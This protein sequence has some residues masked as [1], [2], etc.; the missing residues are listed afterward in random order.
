MATCLRT[1]ACLLFV[2]CAAAVWQDR[3]GE[4]AAIAVEISGASAA[5]SASSSAPIGGASGSK[6]VIE[7]KEDA[8]A[9]RPKAG[10]I[11]GRISNEK[12]GHQA[13]REL[14][15]VSR[16][17]G[18]RY[19]P[20]SFDKEKGA[21]EFK[22]MPGDANY[23]VCVTTED[24]RRI[25]GIDLDFVD[26]GLLRLAEARRDELKMPPD[27]QHAFTSDDAAAL[28]K[29]VADLQDFMEIRRP[30]Y[31][32]GHGRRATM[33]VEL[34]RTREFYSSGDALLWRVELWYFQE[35][36]GAWERV[37]NQEVV[38][39][40]KRITPKEW[41]GIDLEFYPQFS[42]HVG[43]MG[44]AKPMELVIPQAPEA[45]TGR[46]AGSEPE[47]KTTPHVLGLDKDSSNPTTAPAERALEEP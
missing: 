26:E 28:A 19:K 29:F 47:L 24:G 32:Q 12:G 1:A 15:A 34:L 43:R 30:L 33:L 35:N 2:V 3:S 37:P 10:T 42:V 40:R 45:S 21:F 22:D 27:R 39:E 5:S 20:D 17:T 7:I 36:Y 6:R 41:K 38:L 11:K 18:K 23:D 9:Q 14:T 4:S 13:I 44:V 8:P 31:I 25:E 46:P 16:V